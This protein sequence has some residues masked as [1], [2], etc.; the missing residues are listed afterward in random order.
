MYGD[1]VVHVGLDF[2]PK[3]APHA[4]AMRARLADL[5]GVDVGK[6]SVMATTTEKLGFAGRG[7]GI[8]AQAAAVVLLPG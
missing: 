8:A 6:I 2:M 1:G 4:E 7:E 5:L 3:I